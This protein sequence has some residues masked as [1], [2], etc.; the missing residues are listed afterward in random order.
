MQEEGLMRSNQTRSTDP[1]ES[2]YP[3]STNLETAPGLAWCKTKF[4]GC[5]S[6]KCGI[7]EQLFPRPRFA[8]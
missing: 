5:A 2:D 3:T 6:N 7:A 1:H 4:F 8:S